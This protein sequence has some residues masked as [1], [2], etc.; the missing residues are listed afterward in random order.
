MLRNVK[1]GCKTRETFS[2][3]R[4]ENPFNTHSSLNQFLEHYSSSMPKWDWYINIALRLL[5]NLGV[6]ELDVIFHSQ[7]MILREVEWQPWFWGSVSDGD[8]GEPG[9]PPEPAPSP[10][11]HVLSFR[12]KTTNPLWDTL[13][14]WL[15]KGQACVPVAHG[16]MRAS[17]K[18][19]MCIGIYYLSIKHIYGKMHS[20]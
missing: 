17:T 16:K 12:K 10:P 3:G 19:T 4:M 6:F 14:Y 20:S 11:R 2:T 8:R 18:V 9:R 13:G 5:L 7:K 1:T 15:P